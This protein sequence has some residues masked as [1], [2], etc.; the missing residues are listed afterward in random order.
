MTLLGLVSDSPWVQGVFV[1][2][3]T[4]GFYGAVECWRLWL[5]KHEKK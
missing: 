4:V 2:C 3:C 1:I 5:I